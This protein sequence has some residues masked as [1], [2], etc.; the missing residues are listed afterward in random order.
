MVVLITYNTRL[1]RT[2]TTLSTPSKSKAKFGRRQ[3]KSAKRNVEDKSSDELDEAEAD[4]SE[5]EIK[6]TSTVMADLSDCAIA[7]EAHRLRSPET[8]T[9]RPVDG[10][11]DDEQTHGS[12]R[13]AVRANFEPAAP[14]GRG[15]T[16]AAGNA[17]AIRGRACTLTLHVS[18]LAF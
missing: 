2:L 3:P 18:G 9:P 13:T 8:K 14:R 17:R 6:H 10:Y 7:D 1:K 16:G 12:V 4:I 5:T 11:S 15:E